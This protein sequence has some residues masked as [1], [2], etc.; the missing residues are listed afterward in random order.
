[1]ER[2]AESLTIVQCAVLRASRP[3]MQ[4][5]DD[6]SNRKLNTEY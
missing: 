2:Q 4:L 3:P 5:E 1:M 6:R